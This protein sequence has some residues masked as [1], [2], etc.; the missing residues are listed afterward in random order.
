M[1]Q[2]KMKI[3]TISNGSFDHKILPCFV[4]RSFL[5]RNCWIY[6][7]LRNVNNPYRVLFYIFDILF[8]I[9]SKIID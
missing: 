4:S 9:V 7:R 8:N 3:Y 1:Y 6:N 2:N 5:Y